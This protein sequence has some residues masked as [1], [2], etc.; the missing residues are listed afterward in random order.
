MKKARNKFILMEAILALL[1]IIFTVIMLREK[2]KENLEKVSVIIQNADDSRW[3]AFKYGLKMAA[4]DQQVELSVV[5]MGTGLTA[6]EQKNMI[7][8]EIENGAKAIILQP[9]PGDD[10]EIILK[11]IGIKYPVMLVEE[12]TTVQNKKSAL[13]VT[14]PDH[15]A[16]GETLAKELLH[17]YDGKL[18]GK[19]VGIVVESKNSESAKSRENGFREALKG[20][21]VNIVWSIANDEQEDGVKNLQ[22][23][24]KVDIVAALDDDSLVLAGESAYYGNL[25]GALVYGIASSTEAVYYLDAGSAQCL[26]VPNEFNVGYKSMTETAKKLNHYFYKMNS[27]TVSYT[28]L[29]QENLFSEENQKILFTMSQ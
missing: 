13:P 23:Q 17:D 22:N 3:A 5:N 19:R 18:E 26:V 20:T 15:V 14:E 2:E 24:S 16:M 4:Q 12:K 28:V 7:S 25:H 21:G 1:V 9:V 6:E 29:R 10:T 8:R 27:E 11:R